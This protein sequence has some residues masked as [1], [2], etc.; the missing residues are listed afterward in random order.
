[1]KLQSLSSFFVLISPTLQLG[2]GKE[3]N[4]IYFKNLLLLPG[5]GGGGGGALYGEFHLV[6][7][8]KS[9]RQTKEEKEE[10]RKA[11]KKLIRELNFPQDDFAKK[12]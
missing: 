3:E 11:K 12:N 10:S 1:M 5:W 9:K 4:K 6:S 2:P 7:R 8:Q